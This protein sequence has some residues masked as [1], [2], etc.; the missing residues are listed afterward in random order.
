MLSQEL[1][2]HPNICNPQHRKGK[3]CLQVR[4]KMFSVADKKPGCLVAF[5]GKKLVFFSFM[6]DKL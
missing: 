2:Y 1:P 6:L 4:K 5:Q 3:A